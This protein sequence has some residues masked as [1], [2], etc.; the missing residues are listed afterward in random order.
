MHLKGPKLRLIKNPLDACSSV[1]G[2]MNK[3]IQCNLHDMKAFTFSRTGIT[4]IFF[5]T[6]WCV[7]VF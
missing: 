4:F 2:K 7:T 1:D 6:V 5:A 3:V